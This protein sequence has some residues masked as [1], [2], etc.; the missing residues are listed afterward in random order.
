MTR[1]RR[2][3]IF[4]RRPGRER[5]GAGIFLAGTQGIRNWEEWPTEYTGNTEKYGKRKEDGENPE[6]RRAE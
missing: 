1:M 2:A 6:I 3:E 5:I 4:L